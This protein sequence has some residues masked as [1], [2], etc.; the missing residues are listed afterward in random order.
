MSILKSKSTRIYVAGHRGMVGKS[1]CNQLREKGYNNILTVP[2]IELDLRNFQAVS[3]WFNINNP[4][5]VILSA[6]KVGGIIANNSFPADFLLDNLKI[7]NNV[8]ENSWKNGVKRLLFLGSSC[9]YPKFAHQPI[10]EESLLNGKLE[11]TNQWYAIAKIS[12][13]KLCEAL[14]KQYGFD[15]ISLMPTNLYGPGDNFC[16]ENSH[17]IPSLIRKFSKA[18]RDNNSEVIAWGTGNPRREF[19]HVEDLAN[20]SLFALENFNPILNELDTNNFLSY[21]NVGTGMDIT[22][23]ELVDKIAEIYNFKGNVVWDSSKPDGT[24]Q[25]KLNISRISELGWK[26]KITLDIGLTS[27]INYFEKM[28]SSQDLRL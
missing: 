27:T 28:F 22:I 21:L 12:G 4:E 26:S 17:V 1:I 25:K 16:K 18:V 5:V 10:D 13:L 7:Q 2:S 14:R 23:R 8:I 11:E 19:L 24:P 3:K 6:A 20:A 9:I 15:A